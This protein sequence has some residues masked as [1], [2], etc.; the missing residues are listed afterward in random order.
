MGGRRGRARVGFVGL[1]ATV[2]DSP[3]DGSVA[4][5]DGGHIVVAA[6]DTAVVAGSELAEP[7]DGYPLVA[8][9][10]ARSM[11]ARMTVGTTGRV[12]N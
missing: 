6:V 1:P 10:V 5:P 2:E 4:V 12:T 8:G 3:E 11:A 9:V 7:V